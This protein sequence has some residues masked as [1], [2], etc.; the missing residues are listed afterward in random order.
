MEGKALVTDLRTGVQGF[1]STTLL[2]H[3]HRAGE[4]ID[5]TD[6]VSSFVTAAHVRAGLLVAMVQHTTASLIVNEGEPELWKDID[7][8]LG[9]VVPQLG[10]YRHN[11]VLAGPDEHPNAHSHCQSL[12]LTSSI[13]VPVLNG[14]LVLGTYQRLLLIELDHARPR[15][16]TAALLGA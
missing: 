6:E 3:T 7:A 2:F 11:L 1:A 8:M 12:L 5:V 15:R 4:V 16:I 14:R 13:S 9:R 10:D